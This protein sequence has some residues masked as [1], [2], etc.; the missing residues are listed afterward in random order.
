MN[1]TVSQRMAGIAVLLLALLLVLPAMGAV[2]GTTTSTDTAKPFISATVSSITPVVGDPVT[3]SG[4]A[5][6]GNLTAGVQIWVFAGNYI[7]VTTA[8]VN[9]KGEFSKTYQTT[10]L[11][12]ATY[13]SFVQSPSTDGT[14]DIVETDANGFAGQVINTKT[15]ATIFNF[16][17]T[18]SV[19]DMAA[20]T[21]LSNAFNQPNVDDIYTKLSFTLVAPGTTP[22]SPTNATAVT[23]TAVSK[24][25]TTTAKSPVS[26]MTVLAG[27]GLAGFAVVMMRRQ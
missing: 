14:L 11:P 9:A 7:N 19:Q 27:I 23:T 17:G 1:P 13:Y 18:G 15:G 16:T 10:G 5:S 20:V 21:A 12:A 6:G 24:P 8:P 4:I 3:I 25:V 26:F 2:A 22:A